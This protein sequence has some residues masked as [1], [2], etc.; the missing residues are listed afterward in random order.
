[1]VVDLELAQV[2]VLREHPERGVVVHEGLLARE[3]EAAGGDDGEP[4]VPDRLRERRP[5][6]LR[7]DRPL[8]GREGGV[9]LLGSLDIGD[10]HV[11]YK[12]RTLEGMQS[13][14]IEWDQVSLY[15]S[16]DRL[17][18]EIILF[19]NAF[20]SRVDMTFSVTKSFLSTVVGLAWAAASNPRLKVG[21]TMLLP[22]R[23]RQGPGF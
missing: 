20:T 1:M 2:H 15:G 4:A 9:A 7:V 17:S 3:V 13:L 21:T 8:V 11:Y 23:L 6:R 5:R 18:F 19:E 22:G 12:P 14:V 10:G 16:S